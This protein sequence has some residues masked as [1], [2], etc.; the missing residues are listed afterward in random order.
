MII[1][2]VM[3]SCHTSL[4]Q[5]YLSSLRGGRKGVDSSVA[6]SSFEGVERNECLA[7]RFPGHVGAEVSNIRVFTHESLKSGQGLF[8]LPYFS[9][10]D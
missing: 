10:H 6:L 9:E 7:H 5:D 2:L 1:F 8:K 3:S 4:T